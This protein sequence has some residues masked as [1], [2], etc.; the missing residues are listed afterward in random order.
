MRW[1]TLTHCCSARTYSGD[2][3][4]NQA[5]VPCPHSLPLFHPPRSHNVHTRAHT[6]T[7][8]HRVVM[9]RSTCCSPSTKTVPSW[10][11]WVAGLSV[12]AHG[13]SFSKRSK[14]FRPG[15]RRWPRRWCEQASD[16]TTEQPREMQR[17][18][19]SAVRA[20]TTKLCMHAC[21]CALQLVWGFMR[22]TLQ[23]FTGMVP[24]RRRVIAT[25][26]HTHTH[27]HRDGVIY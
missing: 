5:H 27:T 10:R 26:T 7:R 12:L 23:H 4:T 22:K 21:G 14:S 17:V 15:R 20:T 11:C 9:D 3:A 13:A 16:R 18:C 2:M 19:M 6:R 8:I 1:F 24:T 25:H